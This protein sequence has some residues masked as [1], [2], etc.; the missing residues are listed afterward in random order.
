MLNRSIINAGNFKTYRTSSIID[1]SA[2]VV[3]PPY[4]YMIIFLIL[5][6][7]YSIITKFQDNT[8]GR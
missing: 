4:A 6:S 7:S 2:S 1:S 3:K 5:C 8:P